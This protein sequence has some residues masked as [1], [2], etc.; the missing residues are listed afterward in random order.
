MQV[1]NKRRYPAYV[2]CN[3]CGSAAG[4]IGTVYYRCNGCF[5]N[6]YLQEDGSTMWRNRFCYE[7]LN[8]STTWKT[9]LNS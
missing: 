9:F 7:T 4:H 2:I 1:E 3:H 8:S 5:G 6:V